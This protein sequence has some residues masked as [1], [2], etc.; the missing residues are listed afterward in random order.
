MK[1]EAVIETVVKAGGDL[2]VSGDRLRYRLPKDHPEK[3]HILDGLRERKEEIIRL[4]SSRPRTGA[5]S[6]EAPGTRRAEPRS[7]HHPSERE[8]E[9]LQA[10]RIAACGSSHCARCYEAALG[11]RIHP[12]KCGE[13][14]RAWLERWEAKGKPQ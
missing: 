8:P 10:P 3:G 11:V 4:L 1:A 5:P 7:D 12:P 13:D 9:T 6:W 2:T 14:Y